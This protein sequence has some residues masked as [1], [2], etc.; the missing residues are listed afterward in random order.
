MT[1]RTRIAEYE[2]M[3]TGA[4]STIIPTRSDNVKINAR[5]ESNLVLFISFHLPGLYI[6]K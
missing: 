1:T 4:R 2:I 3:T 6:T 5:Y